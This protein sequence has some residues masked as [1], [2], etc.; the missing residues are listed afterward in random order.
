VR[1]KVGFGLAALLGVLVLE[2]ASSS[3]L[4]AQTASIQVPGTLVGIGPQQRSLIVTYT[5]GSLPD[6][7]QILSLTPSVVE[8]TSTV[9][10]TLSA[11]FSVPGEG[12]LNAC[13]LV[14]GTVTVP[15]SAPLAGRAING[16]QLVGG[17]FQAVHEVGPGMPD[18]VGLAPRDARLLLTNPGTPIVGGLVD[19]RVRARDGSQLPTVIAQRP[20]AG[21]PFGP[22]TFVVLTVNR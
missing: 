14:F 2:A 4:D 13:P 1:L 15:L 7:D 16:L 18:L 9:S 21:K 12:A 10:V 17:A 5:N 3:A 8:T 6:C 11:G 19:H 20:A 22:H